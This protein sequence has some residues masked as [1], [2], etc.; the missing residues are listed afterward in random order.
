MKKNF[1]LFTLL[2]GI[3]Y[4]WGRQI[5]VAGIYI[6]CNE[7]SLPG[8]KI[9]K[10]ALV[11]KE[12]CMIINVPEGPKSEPNQRGHVTIFDQNG[13]KIDKF[14]FSSYDQST[15]EDGISTQLTFQ[16]P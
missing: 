14:Q 10:C 8:Y 16:L 3:N 12:T 6:G 11:S 7:T 4:S 13:E 9:C 1:L 2:L 5:P 15:S